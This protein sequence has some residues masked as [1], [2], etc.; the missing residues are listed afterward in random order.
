M[1]VPEVGV[2]SCINLA[3]A[4]PLISLRPLDAISFMTCKESDSPAQGKGRLHWAGGGRG[5][6]ECQRCAVLFVRCKKTA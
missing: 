5:V 3:P 1:C 6:H 2:S 4:S